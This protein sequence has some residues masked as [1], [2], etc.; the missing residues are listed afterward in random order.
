M[1]PAAVRELIAAG[2]SLL[3]GTH[4]GSLVPEATRATGILLGADGASLTV[5]VPDATGRRALVNLRSDPRVA[6]TCSHPA[7]H[8]TF[9]LKGRVTA[10]RRAKGPDRDVI[11]RYRSA[12]SGQLE[13]VGISPEV[14]SRLSGWP[15]HAIE[16]TVT[17]IFEQ[18]PGPGA[19]E[20]LGSAR[21]VP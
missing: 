18:T 5:F 6:I 12:F 1:I 21:G 15:A 19:G 2:P 17:E 10:V 3:I 13:E 9:Q 8:L 20:R 11:E 14:S 4:D 16:V 7:S